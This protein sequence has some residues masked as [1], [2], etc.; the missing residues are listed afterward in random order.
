ASD[1]LSAGKSSSLGDSRMAAPEDIVTRVAK[2]AISCTAM[3]TASRPSMLRV[4]QDLEA[5]RAEVGGGVKSA[6][7][8][9]RVD[10]NIVTDKVERTIDEDLELL[11][12]EFS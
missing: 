4:A 11:N 1:L 3:P 7:G 12:L 8:A 9:A 10:A 2:L 6:P 5:L